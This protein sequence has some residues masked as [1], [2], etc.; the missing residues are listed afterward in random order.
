MSLTR[1]PGPLARETAPTNYTIEGPAHRLFF[2]DFP[3][4]VRAELAG[5]VVL[6]TTRA[7]LLH[8][9]GLLPQVYV[10]RKDLRQDML[11]DSDH[12]THCPFKGDASYLSVRAGG[13]FAENAFW[14]Y[15]EPIAGTEWL[16]DHVGVYF[17]RLDRWLDEDEEVAGHLR[18]PYHRVDV[19]ATS[20]H[21]YVRAGD[22][23]L[24]DSSR[25][26]LLSETSVPNRFYIAR[27]DVDA[28]LRRSEKTAVCPYKGT[29]TYWSVVLRDGTVVE[30][31]AW[32][33]EEP[34]PGVGAIAGRVSFDHEAL[35]VLE[36][37]PEWAPGATT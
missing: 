30:D 36:V 17:D 8:E 28:E 24:T 14:I 32:S 3:R 15:E 12:Q 23:V 7:K 11:E 21:V 2:H 34:L 5:E 27:E 19:R 29:A 31:A 33:Y 16:R 37:A 22:D 6:D 18:D 4:R 25:T 35:D 20:R 26:L 9:T 13:G 1:P 10:P